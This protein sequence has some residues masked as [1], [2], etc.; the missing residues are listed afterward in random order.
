ND[1][2]LDN[3]IY[4]EN[5]EIIDNYEDGINNDNDD[6]NEEIFIANMGRE[7]I[8]GTQKREYLANLLMNN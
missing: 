7:R 8:A 3:D 1:L 6:E 2:L 5:S 4:Y